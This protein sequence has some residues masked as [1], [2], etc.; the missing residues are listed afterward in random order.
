MSRAL[1]TSVSVAGCLALVAAAPATAAPTADFTVAP[2]QI[3]AYEPAT[4]TSASTGQDPMTIEWDFDDNGTVDATGPTAVHTF[5]TSGSVSVKLHVA[6]ST[7]EDTVTRLLP[8]AAPT[9]PVAGFS[10]VPGVPLAGSSATFTSTSTTVPGASIATVQWDF[11]DNGTVDASGQWVSH[12]FA[13]GGVHRVRVHVVDTR[14]LSAD[15]TRLVTVNS[16]P[17]AAFTAFPAAPRVGDELSL[18]SYSSDAEG[19]L[20]DQRWDLDGDGA[21]DDASGAVVTGTFTTPG[22]HK[23]SLRVTDGQ[24]AIATISRTISVSAPPAEPST[25]G[26]PP[27]EQDD[28][29]T[30]PAGPVFRVLLSP[31]PVVR[32]AGTVT[33]GGARIRMLVVRAP[34]GARVLVRCRGKRCPA[35]SYT[36]VASR[37][38]IRFR[39]LERFLPAGSVIE[40]LV[41]RGDQIGKYTSF[42]IRRNRVP[43]RTDA[44]L[45]PHASRGTECPD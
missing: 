40:V 11:D 13:T 23:V 17:S 16:P 45:T 7:G 33:A 1:I 2:Q 38:P 44:C 20:A 18:T 32:L 30:T 42:R 27:A 39:A 36:K 29:P 25:G 26:G 15:A 21:F 43:K 4:F 35:R 12:T 28:P 14:N 24:G 19:A 10:V 41:R 6:D 34:R 8:V 9:L 5:T 31:F 3:V 37:K 22:D